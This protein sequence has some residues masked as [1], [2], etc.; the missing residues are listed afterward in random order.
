MEVAF[1]IAAA[2]EHA[3]AAL[4]SDAEF[5]VLKNSVQRNDRAYGQRDGHLH[6][7]SAV[8]DVDQLSGVTAAD[9]IGS[10]GGDLESWRQIDSAA[11]VAASFRGNGGHMN[12]IGWDGSMV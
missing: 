5:L 3:G 9:S 8:T 7:D 10:V 12:S 4:N 1:L 11:G 2:V 6:A